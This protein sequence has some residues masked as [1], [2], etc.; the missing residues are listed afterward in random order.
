MNPLEFVHEEFENVK[1]VLKETLRHD[2]LPQRSKRYFEECVARLGQIE[3]SIS[4]LTQTDEQ[5]V[6]QYC[7]ELTR[8]A[9]WISLIERSHLGE[10]SWPFAEELDRLARV[11]L[12]ENNISGQRIEPIVH[13]VS[14]SLQGYRIFAESQVPAI[15]GSQRFVT[16][17]FPRQLRHHVL[18][19]S[20]FGHEICHVAFVNSTV[21]GSTI[22]G[23]VL[24][25]LTSSGPFQ[26]VATLNQ[27]LHDQSAPQTIKDLLTRQYKKLG[28]PYLLQQSTWQYWLTELICDLFGLLLFGPAFMGAHS[29]ILRPGSPNAYEFN[30]DNAT[31]P[32]FSVRRKALIRALIILGWDQPITNAHRQPYYAAE[33][34][35]LKFLAED[36]YDPWALAFSDAQLRTAIAAIQKLFLSFDNVGFK[37]TTAQKLEA[38]LERLS[39]GI[40]PVIADVSIEGYAHLETTDITLILYAGWVYWIGREHFQHGASK[41]FLTNRLCDHALLQQQAINLAISPGDREWESWAVAP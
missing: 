11:L 40:P 25:A 3:K 38:L 30:V 41:F 14:E 4:N 1:R 36:T 39:N 32:P 23:P 17:A 20:L 35:Y 19:H 29:T 9:H 12:A 5:L 34:E 7:Q 15:S 33:Q 37:R 22:H 26:S 27:W 18:L 10:F 8:L 28:R 13:V 21:A 24:T 16:V 2:F 31:H 6:S